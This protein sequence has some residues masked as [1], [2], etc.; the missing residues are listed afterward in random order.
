MSFCKSLL[1]VFTKL[2]VSYEEFEHGENMNYAIIQ[3]CLANRIEYKVILINGCPKYH[4]TKGNGVSFLVLP[5]LYNFA[6]KAIELLRKN[7]KSAILDGLV[8]VDI[9]SYKN[10]MIVNEFESL[11]ANYYGN[12]NRQNNL[13]SEV[14]IFL[15]QYWFCQLESQYQKSRFVK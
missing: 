15:Q 6:I 5:D 13:E 14:T 11:E 1:E 12:G 4:A 3:P 7:C 2:R 9:M 8:R 10:V